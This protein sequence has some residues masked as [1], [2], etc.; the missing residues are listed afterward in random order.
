MLAP[1]LVPPC[2]ITSVLVLKIFMKEQGPLAKPFVVPTLSPAGRRREKLNP[3]PPPILCTS[4]ACFAASKIP[5]IESSTGSTK[6]ADMVKSGRPALVR[7]GVLG[8]KRQSC[9]TS[10]NS[11]FCSAVAAIALDTRSQSPGQSSITI[12]CESFRKY[13]S[14]SI[15]SLMVASLQ[16]D[17][18]LIGLVDEIVL[19][20]RWASRSV[21]FCRKELDSLEDYLELTVFPA[22]FVFPFPYLWVSLDED[23]LSRV[24]VLRAQSPPCS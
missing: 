8:R 4:A 12:P 10:K 2:F 9:I 7:A 19:P 6:H 24:E 1:R 22:V 16:R 17:I 18:V 5:S 23:E 20:V 3:V 13:R 14:L 15:S 21:R 11:R